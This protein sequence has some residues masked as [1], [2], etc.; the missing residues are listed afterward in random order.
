M[1]RKQAS[2]HFSSTHPRSKL[3]LF[4]S[5]T[6][7]STAALAYHLTAEMCFNA[8]RGRRPVSVPQKS[9]QKVRFANV[10]SGSSRTIDGAVCPF[11]LPPPPPISYQPYQPPAASTYI[12]VPTYPEASNTTTTIA[13]NTDRLASEIAQ[14]LVPT[15]TATANNFS[16]TDYLIPL[17]NGS[18]N[19]TTTDSERSAEESRAEIATLSAKLIEDEAVR[20]VRE[21]N[22]RDDLRTL[23]ERA[24]LRLDREFGN[25][26]Q[27]R[28]RPQSRS[29]SRSRSESRRRSTDRERL[30]V[31]EEMPSVTVKWCT[32]CGGR[33]HVS[34]DCEVIEYV[35]AGIVGDRISSNRLYYQPRQRVRYV[36]GL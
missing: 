28:L 18:C 34:D 22:R 7:L 27:S 36:S 30:V 2:T 33:G 35:D 26:S 23:E 6:I 14:I 31:V 5:E 19:A 21:R 3:P 8:D 20:R 11:P 13:T 4:Y 15:S 17:N 24:R 1:E 25:A 16:P 12:C 29:H 10:N 32:Q 9:R